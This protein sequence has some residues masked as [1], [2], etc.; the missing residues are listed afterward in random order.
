MTF[1]QGSLE[2]LIKS[3]TIKS[4]GIEEVARSNNIEE[5]PFSRD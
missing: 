4:C 2:N 3:P 1:S 5:L